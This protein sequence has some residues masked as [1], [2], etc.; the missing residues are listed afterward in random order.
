MQRLFE[1]VYGN[2]CRR[3]FA[4]IDVDR[5]ADTRRETKDVDFLIY[6]KIR[7]NHADFVRTLIQP[8]LGQLRSSG[9]TYE[10]IRYK[11]YDYATYQSLLTRSRAMIFL[12]EHETQGKA[13]Q[14]CLAA[15]VPVLAWDN[16]YWLDP[17][18]T[19]Y[20][21]DPVPSSS[22]PYFSPECG[23]RFTGI[24]DFYRTL[25]DFLV[26]LDTNSPRAYVERELSFTRSAQLYIDAFESA[27]RR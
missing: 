20:T 24:D 7:C 15:N 12:C 22:V 2:C 21:N 25:G 23:E 10:V 27:G 18:R 4:G 3:W 14:E 1:P 5:W 17:N 13:Y 9:L 16:G 11:Y 19:L 8:I 6:D 26:R